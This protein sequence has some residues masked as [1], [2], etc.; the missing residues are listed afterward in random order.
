VRRR[1]QNILRWS[2]VLL[3][4]VTLLAYLSPTIDPRSVWYFSILGLIF[5]ILFFANLFFIIVWIALKR[6]N[7]LLS[8]GCLLIGWGSLTNFARFG[9]SAQPVTT[10]ESFTIL[11][12]NIMNGRGINNPNEAPVAVAEYLNKQDPSIFCLQE[13]FVQKE[14]IRRFVE[15]LNTD[16]KYHYPIDQRLFI[17]SK[18]PI[19]HTGELNSMN[20]TNGCTFA[21]LDV[22]GQRIRV[23]NPHLLTNNITDLA[24]DVARR[25][26]LQEK[27]TWGKVGNM[28]RYY[29]R[30]AQQRVT[31]AANIAAHIEQCP[32]PV[33]VGGDFNDVPLSYSYQLLSENLQ[34]SFRERGSGFGTT[35]A[36]SIPLLRIDYILASEK[37]QFRS[38]EVLKITPNYSDHF[39]IMATLEF[40]D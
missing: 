7:F 37:A 39:P 12:H 16:Y 17:G 4:L 29:K 24:E 36:G 5:P 27:E 8:L 33:L 15:T 40:A 9:S 19:I 20:H 23:Y 35:Y 10:N 11:S 1:I 38:H 6:W 30:A 18:Y 21:D 26:E 14:H 25:G 3:V 32:Y 28:F 34:D 31:Q 2:N 13:F 22:N